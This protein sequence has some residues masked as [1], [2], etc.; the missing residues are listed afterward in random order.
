[1]VQIAQLNAEVRSCLDNCYRAAHPLEKMTSW[2][3]RLRIN[4]KWSEAE[5]QEVESAVRRV[6]LG[7][8]K[9][10]T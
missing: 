2:L 10:S 5:V 3:G 8:F 7:V 4:P 1:M 9:L 6:L